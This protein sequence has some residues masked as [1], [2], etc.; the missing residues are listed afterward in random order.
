[1]KN[2]ACSTGDNCVTNEQEAS[3]K[4]SLNYSK[5]IDMDP[6]GL[7]TIKSHNFIMH[8]WK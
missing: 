2:E 7:S 1:M 4:L 6:E 5:I 3:G 8:S